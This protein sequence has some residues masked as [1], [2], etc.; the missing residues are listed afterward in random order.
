MDAYLR[1]RLHP[2]ERLKP[3]IMRKCM[4]S[5]V[6]HIFWQSFLPSVCVLPRY[7]MTHGSRIQQFVWQI[8]CVW[9]ETF[10]S[11]LL[12][13]ICLYSCAGFDKPEEWCLKRHFSMGNCPRHWGID[14]YESNWVE[15]GSFL[16]MDEPTSLFQRGKNTHTVCGVGVTW[17]SWVSLPAVR[18]RAGLCKVTDTARGCLPSPRTIN[19]PLPPSFIH[20]T[21]STSWLADDSVVIMLLYLS[22]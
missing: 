19:P 13:F 10:I 17:S 12:P 8:L 22:L 6:N 7:C 18:R 21:C 14:K 16:W 3:Y 11:L 20:L 15:W 1:V 4:S 9:K 2:V 5:R